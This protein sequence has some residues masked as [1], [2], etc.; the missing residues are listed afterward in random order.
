MEILKVNEITST[1]DIFGKNSNIVVAN[2][3]TKLMKVKKKNQLN[4]S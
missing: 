4:N 2:M 3:Y 1:I